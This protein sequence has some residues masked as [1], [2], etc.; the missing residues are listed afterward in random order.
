MGPSLQ[1]TGSRA[2]IATGCELWQQLAMLQPC[3]M[4]TEPRPECRKLCHS[5][6]RSFY[7]WRCLQL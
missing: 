6:R 1:N 7:P 4:M 3:Q 2:D 5:S